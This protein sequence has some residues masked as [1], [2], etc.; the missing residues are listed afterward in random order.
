MPSSAACGLASLVGGEPRDDFVRISI[1]HVAQPA[2]PEFSHQCMT[3]V[4]QVIVPWI[5]ER[6]Y[7][8]E[9]DVDETPFGRRSVLGA[10]PARPR[11]GRRGPLDPREQ[12]FRVRCNWVVKMNS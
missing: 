7:E 4:E 6:E 11:I 10:L 5:S 3:K 9:V 2:P 12:A 1:D 8:R